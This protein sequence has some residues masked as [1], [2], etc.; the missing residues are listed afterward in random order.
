MINLFAL[1]ILHTMTVCILLLLG[2]AIKWMLL[3]TSTRKNRNY[4]NRRANNGK[5]IAKPTPEIVWIVGP[6]R[7]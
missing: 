2:V 7:L 4:Y 3:G 5:Y 1:L 6:D